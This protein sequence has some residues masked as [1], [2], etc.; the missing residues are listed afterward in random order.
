MSTFKD[1]PKWTH[2][3]F[4]GFLMI[5]AAYCD[6]EFSEKER[7]V[8]RE[9]INEIKLKE[10]EAEYLEMND[11][12]RINT[13][14]AYREKYFST[15]AEKKMIYSMLESLFQVDGQFSIMEKNL[16]RMLHKLL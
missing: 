4:V 14:N 12:E 11:I 1:H 3:E 8:I 6:M 13:I 7:A 9:N 2:N 15:E 16:M 10:L 5:Y